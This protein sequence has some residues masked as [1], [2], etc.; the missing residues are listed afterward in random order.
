MRNLLVLSMALTALSVSAQDVAKP[1]YKVSGGLLA[2]A[3]VYKVKDVEDFDKSNW[4]SKFGFDG[5]VWFNLPLGRVLS[6]EPQLLYSSRGVEAENSQGTTP[7]GSANFFSIPVLVKVGLGSK[8]ALMAGPQFDFLT[9]F[10]DDNNNN[11]KDNFRS[12]SIGFTTGL[13]LF[14]HN[15]LSLYGRYNWMTNDFFTFDD[16][17]SVIKSDHRLNGFH[18]GLKFRLFGGAVAAAAAVPL[19]A[20]AIPPPDT[21][22]DGIP[23]K[24]D[25]CPNQPGTA[26]YGGC[27]IPDSDG[28]GLNDEQ[29]KCPNQA[30]TAKYQG[31]PIP[32]SDGDGINDENDKCPNQAGI[33]KY[34]GCPIPD[35][36]NDGVNDEE[37]LCPNT[38]GI[39]ENKGCPDLTLYYKRAV[40]ALDANDKAQLDKVVK[41]MNDHPSVR[42][43]LEG[44][45]ST[46]G[47]TDYNQKL[48]DRRAANCKKYLVSK[49]I[50][51]DRIDAVGYGEQFPIGDNSIEEGR[52]KSRRVVVKAAK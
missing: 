2:G 48:S 30:G 26:K 52:A 38:P 16:G 4:K 13:E 15:R 1:R 25:R 27:P 21:D 36:D 42:I 40:D 24:D 10:K 3:N 43:L 39:V 6:L 49:G 22:G 45:T 46:L 8:L 33:A 47:A 19:V 23:D 12:S 28:D 41:F 50:A 18:F 11:D 35:S 20:A 5:G 37:D 51:A 44:H 34:G 29:D 14:P 17:N 32:D 31:C 7:K 9:K